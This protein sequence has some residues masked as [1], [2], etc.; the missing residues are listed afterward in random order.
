METQHCDAFDY[1]GR[2]TE[3]TI[4]SGKSH[5]NLKFL[6]NSLF[7]YFKNRNVGATK[8]KVMLLFGFILITRKQ[9]T[10]VFNRAIFIV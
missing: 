6:V 4:S 2:G 8:V 7:Y 3:V 10:D 9:Q 5:L 1:W